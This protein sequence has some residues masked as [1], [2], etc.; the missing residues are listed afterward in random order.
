MVKY[1]ALRGHPRIVLINGDYR[2]ITLL[3]L[4]KRSLEVLAK[5]SLYGEPFSYYCIPISGLETSSEKFLIETIRKSRGTVNGEKKW[6]AAAKW[7]VIPGLEESCISTDKDI[8]SHS[9]ST[10]I[11]TSEWLGIIESYTDS[12]FIYN[13]AFARANLAMRDTLVEIARLH[14]DSPDSWSKYRIMYK[15]SG[16]ASGEMLKCW[17]TEP[18]NRPGYKTSYVALQTWTG[19]PMKGGTA[20]WS[21]PAEAKPKK[22]FSIKNDWREAIGVAAW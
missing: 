18:V 6:R 9:Y 2:G 5:P 19:F 8:V 3:K 1:V 21:I 4:T 14:D 17:S 12:L 10:D 16:K 13:Q 11:H 7:C 22:V 20:S 15:G